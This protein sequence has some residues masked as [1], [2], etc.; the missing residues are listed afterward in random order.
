MFLPQHTHISFSLYHEVSEL[1]GHGRIAFMI[2]K[3]Q[4]KRKKG[5]IFS[6]HFKGA[7]KTGMGNSTFKP[8]TLYCVIAEIVPAMRDG[9]LKKKH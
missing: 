8:K 9:I 3:V 5:V 4:T 1:S 7:H 6:L 2:L